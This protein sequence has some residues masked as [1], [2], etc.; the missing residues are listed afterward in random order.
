MRVTVPSAILR[1]S[2][3]MHVL[4]DGETEG[5]GGLAK[6]EEGRTPA[7]GRCV[8]ASCLLRMSLASG[9]HTWLTSMPRVPEGSWQQA[10][11]YWRR[12][13]EGAKCTGR[14]HPRQAVFSS[15]HITFLSCLPLSPPP[16]CPS[17]SPR[18]PQPTTRRPRPRPRP[19]P[20]L[21]QR[22]PTSANGR[23]ATA[24]SPTQRCS[25]P[26]SATI[27]SAA[28]AQTTSA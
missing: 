5:V 18:R 24:L 13:Q 2:R 10:P 8:R 16:P 27:I 20:T 17:S 14:V 7:E 9:C 3:K 26:I 23:T 25:T 28:R 4:V 15:A 6:A 22:L 12:G 19:P 21:P 1:L 11:S